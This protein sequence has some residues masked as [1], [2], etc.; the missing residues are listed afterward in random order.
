M[1]LTDAIARIRTEIG[2]P[3]QPFMTSTLGDGMTSLYDLPKQNID[4]G[5]LTVT[6]VNGANTSVLTEDIDYDVNDELGYVQLRN[7]VP[8]GATIIMQGSAWGLF[9]DDDITTLINDSVNQHCLN[10]F[11]KERTRNR[12]GFISFRKTPMNLSNLPP[13]EEPLLITLTVLNTLWVLA[14][15]A[16]TD[17]NIQTAEGTNVDRIARYQQLMAHI[18]ELQERYERYCGQLNVGM[19]RTETLKLRRVSRTTGRLIPIF[20]DREYDDHAWP[21]RQLPP[22]DGPWEDDSGIPSPLWNGQGF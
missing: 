22:I 21:T 5:S 19:F 8:N 20:E 7:A 14:N 11:I 4:E 15:D 3:L 12:Q 13:I 6:I 1:L 17:T 16:A 9:T 2:D 10:R 18:A